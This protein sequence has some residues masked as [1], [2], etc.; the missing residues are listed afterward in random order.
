MGCLLRV[1]VPAFLWITAIHSA[2]AGVV[3][4]PRGETVW[5]GV[6]TAAQAGRGR[7]AYAANCSACHGADLEG[8]NAPS[9]KGDLFMLHWSED[10]LDALFTRVKSMPPRTSAQIS[11]AMHLDM[12]AH[13]LSV[14]TFPAGNEALTAGTLSGIR[15]E[16]RDG[17]GIVPPG[18]LVEVAGCLTSGPDQT[19]LLTKGT[20]LVRTRNPNQPAPAELLTPAPLGTETYRLLYPESFA[21]GFRAD[22]HQGHKMQARGFLIRN[23]ADIRI[24]VTWLE[25]LSETCN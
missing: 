24:N 11:E 3:Q 5:D 16:S 18:A 13:I 25:M 12:L 17:P 1:L 8:A 9:L 21:P 2:E 14:N 15:V 6:F 22:A 4:A 19:W 20:P 23:P 7:E 10:S